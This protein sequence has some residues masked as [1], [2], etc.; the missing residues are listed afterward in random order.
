MTE[1]STK[2]VLQGLTSLERDMIP[3]TV[4]VKDL[5]VMKACLI[6]APGQMSTRSLR[7][8][9]KAGRGSYRYDEATMTLHYTGPVTN[10]EGREGLCQK[11]GLREVVP[12]TGGRMR[13]VACA[14]EDTRPQLGIL[15]AR[16]E[17]YLNRMKIHEH[18]PHPEDN[19]LRDVGMGQF[20]P[21]SHCRFCKELHGREWDKEYEER[22]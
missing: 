1:K 12:G 8:M 5:P 19:E 2:E 22:S 11:H 3:E 9:A 10:I 21:I 7:A 13:C 6:R 14:R 20:D 4:W 18:L 16:D 17:D 15:W